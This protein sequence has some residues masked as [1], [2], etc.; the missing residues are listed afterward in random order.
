MIRAHK[1]NTIRP[2]GNERYY[3][4]YNIYEKRSQCDRRVYRVLILLYTLRVLKTLYWGNRE[5]AS[6]SP[7]SKLR[8]ARKKYLIHECKNTGRINLL[9]LLLV[10][11]NPYTVALCLIV[12]NEG[13]LMVWTNFKIENA[14]HVIALLTL[15]LRSLPT[16]LPN[17]IK[18]FSGHRFSGLSNLRRKENL[19]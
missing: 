15:P 1:L 6:V 3:N 9:L 13:G 12:T 16:I 4:L 17:G 18:M 14:L 19:L 10:L 5:I 7:T 8:L 2:S 11:Q